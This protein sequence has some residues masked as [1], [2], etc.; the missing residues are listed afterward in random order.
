VISNW[1]LSPNL[2]GLFWTVTPKRDTTDILKKYALICA[3]RWMMIWKTRR[4]GEV[5]YLWKTRMLLD[6]LEE[7]L[8]EVG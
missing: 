3:E 2:A 5:Q 8:G 1:Y 7:I 6:G 4:T